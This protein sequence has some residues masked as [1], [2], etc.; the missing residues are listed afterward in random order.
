MRFQRKS[1]HTNGTRNEA[2]SKE[3]ARDCEQKE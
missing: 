2:A 3:E 1:F